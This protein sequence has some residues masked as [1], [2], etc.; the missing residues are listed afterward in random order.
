MSLRRRGSGSGIGT[1]DLNPTQPQVP[2]NKSPK[3]GKELIVIPLSTIV[4]S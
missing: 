3:K 2:H 1:L 4:L